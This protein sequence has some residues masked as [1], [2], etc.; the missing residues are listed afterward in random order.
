MIPDEDKR[1][2]LKYKQMLDGSKRVSGSQIGELTS[3]YNRTFGTK[4]APTNCSS[5]VRQRISKLHDRL[6]RENNEGQ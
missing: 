4:L 1:L 6:L 2:I 5:C 3:L